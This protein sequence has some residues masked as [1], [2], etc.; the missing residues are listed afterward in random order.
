M[1]PAGSTRVVH[2]DRLELTLEPKPWAYADANR[3]AIDA[4][5]ADTQK[6]KP[7][8]FNG[9]VL[10]MHRCTIDG[11]VMSGGFMEAD[12][13]SFTFWITSGRPKAGIYDCFGAAAV[14]SSDGAF[15]LGEMAAHTFNAGQVYFPCGTPDLSDLVGHR[16]DFDMS[17]RRELKEETGIDAAE[18]TDERG[19]TLVIEADLICAIKV[20]RSP[21]AAEPLRVRTLRHLASERQPE[22]ADIKVVRS[23]DDFSPNMRSFVHLFLSHRF[24]VAR[25]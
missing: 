19:W 13:A 14:M 5:F 3:P 4:L 17:V 6:K 9:R 15:L 16:V 1:K 24:A 8:L 10:L 11:G 20:M 21:L 25:R 18:L 23:K 7:A 2:V 22:L 12:Y